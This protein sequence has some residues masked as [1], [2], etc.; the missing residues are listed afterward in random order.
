MIIGPTSTGAGS[1][2]RTPMVLR[3]LA[4]ALL[5]LAF[6][7]GAHAAA[8]G[9]ADCKP[10]P[11]RDK[12]ACPPSTPEEML[13]YFQRI[14]RQGQ[15]KLLSAMNRLNAS[16]ETTL[17]MAHMDPS[18]CLDVEKTS[19][20]QECKRVNG[21]L[22]CVTGRTEALPGRSGHPEAGAPPELSLYLAHLAVLRKAGS[23]GSAATLLG[24]TATAAR[25]DE[26]SIG[27]LTKA[28]AAD[29]AAG[30]NRAVV[31]DRLMLASVFIR[32]GDFASA[33]EHLNQAD[34]R[35]NEDEAK[36]AVLANRG[37]SSALQGDLATGID[38]TLR[39]MNL[40]R[41]L[42]A[43]AGGAGGDPER[44]CAYD[45]P[46]DTA[47]RSLAARSVR[48]GLELSLL[49]LGVMHA[50]L[51]QFDKAVEQVNKAI[52]LHAARDGR[53]S[54]AAQSAMASVLLRA[55]RND[56]ARAQANVAA[57]SGPSLLLALGRTYSARI[58]LRPAI[59]TAAMQAA[60]AGGAG[61]SS[62]LQ[63]SWAEYR[64]TALSAEA[65]GASDALRPAL[66]NLQRTAAAMQ[67]KEL[68][69]YYGKRAVNEVQRQ[70]AG[71]ANLSSETRKT[72]AASSRPVYE[73]LAAALLEA[74][75]LDEAEHALLLAH[76]DELAEFGSSAGVMPMNA[77][78]RALQQHDTALVARWRTAAAER[79]A[80]FAKSPAVLRP[81]RQQVDAQFDMLV[82]FVASTLS[83]LAP[84][85]R[86]SAATGKGLEREAD[87][88][89][90]MLRPVLCNAGAVDPRLAV[91]HARLVD[92]R[93]QIAA[94]GAAT[95]PPSAPRT[96]AAS[97]PADDS[98]RRLKC[99]QIEQD[100]AEA[101]ATT[102]N[103]RLVAALVST[104]GGIDA[105]E[106]ALLDRNRLALA[107]PSGRAP[108]V[109]LQYL[110]TDRRLYVLVVTSTRRW[111]AQVDI[112]RGDLDAKVT[113]FR[114]ALQTPGPVPLQLAGDLYKTLV[115]PVADQLE[116]EAPALLQLAPDGSLRLLPFAALR[117]PDG[118]LIERYALTVGRPLETRAAAPRKA[119]R[120]AGFAASAAAPGLAPLPFAAEEVRGLIG[121]PGAAR[122]GSMEGVA[123]ID[124][125]FTAPALRKALA[126]G[127]PVIHIASHF[128][129]LPE[130]AGESYLALGDA[131]RLS[132]QRIREE[133]RFDGVELITLSACET[134][135]NAISRYGQEFEGL[136]TVLR[137]NGAAS[138]LATLWPV[139]D[140]GTSLFMRTFYAAHQAQGLSRAEALRFAQRA[141]IGGA[142]TVGAD[143]AAVRPATTPAPTAQDGGAQARGATLRLPRGA[144]Q[145]SSYAHPFFWAPFVLTGDAS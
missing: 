120:V 125:A 51:G 124:R 7:Q 50:Q 58:T 115:A 11:G 70:R 144:A 36:A 76:Q 53:G 47:R 16:M 13:E 26:W 95:P 122:P 87:D 118:W 1:Q 41:S 38:H 45:V 98:I 103:E 21:Q 110:V 137:G 24:G 66:A 63:A 32:S 78:E 107:A 85:Q 40:Y 48:T 100:A 132:L 69:I 60:S 14:N 2:G 4:V 15:D 28:L 140:P 10:G 49:N 59:T 121:G 109:A 27:S 5:C 101:S 114:Q 136:S 96:R 99:S 62:D 64:K 106:Q 111:V 43:A 68:S 73:A 142:A 104:P 117:G 81:T 130:S 86:L 135:L 17:A 54:A 123:V 72:F 12:A 57:R 6:A 108:A 34:R 77:A 88:L 102:L 82:Q 18:Y 133:L 29:E 37:V 67:R 9:A 42:D 75:R 89:E 23:E 74:G 129:L 139:S 35:A 33:S 112:D 84:M 128:V 8:G 134:G 52:A 30:D 141:L 91:H 94:S 83:A 143:T 31:N 3:L 126:Q 79:E 131:T 25:D 145:S 19:P 92:L 39:A 93:R 105:G 44:S 71:L 90:S 56:D 61:G 22:T 46:L 127:Y 55:G 113:R 116:R 119:W 65:R 97:P 138:V 20:P 80:V